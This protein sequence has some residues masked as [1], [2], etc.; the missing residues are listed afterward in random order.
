M[1]ASFV[2]SN[3]TDVSPSI[4]FQPSIKKSNETATSIPTPLSQQ[5][6]QQQNAAVPTIQ[7][8]L[9]DQSIPLA[10]SQP[11]DKPDTF[12]SCKSIANS[13]CDIHDDPTNKTSGTISEKSVSNSIVVNACS[14]VQ[15]PPDSV[16][17]IV[18]DEKCDAVADDATSSSGDTVAK[19]PRECLPLNASPPKITVVCAPCT[20]EMILESAAAARQSAESIECDEPIECEACDDADESS[21]VIDLPA[22]PKS[23]SKQLSLEVRKCSEPT[24][25][26]EDLSP[27]MDEY[28]G[29]EIFCCCYC[30]FLISQK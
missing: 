19:V 22:S 2:K 1:P 8:S 7:S 16:H 11:F 10:T 3:S 26:R 9:S 18:C 14:V 13:A 30:W 20:E 23:I 4:I 17:A 6:Q 27:N 21:I 5:Q 12:A 28:Q 15:P 29:K 24:I 25:T